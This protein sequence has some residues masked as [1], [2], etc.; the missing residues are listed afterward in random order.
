M[1]VTLA[2]VQ[3]VQLGACS[4]SF[5]GKDLGLTKGGVKVT[6]STQTKTIQV[7]QFGETIVNDYIMGRSGTVTVPMAESDLTKLAAAIPG[8]VLITDAISQNLQ[9]QIPT[10]VGTS[11]LATAKSLV[12]HP[13]A[14]AAT[15]LTQDVTI[16]LAA[17]TSNISFEFQYNNERVYNIEFTMY[18][19][20]ATGLMVMLGDPTASAT[21]TAGITISAGTYVAATGLLTLTTATA[22]GHAADDIVAI[23]SPTGTGAVAAAFAGSD[24]YEVVSCSGTSLVIQL[25]TNLATFTVTGGTVDHA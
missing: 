2:Q 23:T 9:L 11:L 5:G 22:T 10:S 24:T 21:S 25:P 13:T 8:A 20:P 18:P 15:N 17:V 12:L 19:N 16:P 4:V 1:S 14:N 3:N 7:D 6:I